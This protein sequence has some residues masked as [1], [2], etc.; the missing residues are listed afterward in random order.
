MPRRVG[1]RDRRE[2]PRR[3]LEEAGGRVLGAARLGAADR[4][5]A[6]EARRAVRRRTTDALVEP[7]SVT[8]ASPLAASTAATVAGSCA[9]GAATTASSTPE[10]ASSRLA[11]AVTAP[12][13]DCGGERTG[14]RV[15]AD[16][17]VAAPLR[18]ERDGGADQPGADDCDPHRA[19]LNLVVCVAGIGSRET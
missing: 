7:T 11:A 1:V 2:E 16:D 17:L 10:T 6:D 12:T 8:V 4:V 9:I 14:L 13:L 5:P 19:P 15:P 3:A 18:G